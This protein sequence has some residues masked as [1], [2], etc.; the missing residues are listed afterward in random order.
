MARLGSL[1]LF[2]GAVSSFR[3]LAW[4]CDVI[5]SRHEIRLKYVTDK[6]P[7]RFN[8]TDETDPLRIDYCDQ[9]R[10]FFF[11]LTFIYTG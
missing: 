7:K 4:F 10:F 1:R 2:K 8:E 6:L 9:R 11:L 3:I 5:G